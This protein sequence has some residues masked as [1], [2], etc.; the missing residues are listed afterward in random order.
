MWFPTGHSSIICHGN[1]VRFSTMKIGEQLNGA[2]TSWW[3][4]TCTARLWAVN[5]Y[6]PHHHTLDYKLGRAWMEKSGT[7]QPVYVL[8]TCNTWQSAISNVHEVS[9]FSRQISAYF[10][11]ASCSVLNLHSVCTPV[12]G[13][14]SCA[15]LS[16][17]NAL[18]WK[19]VRCSDSWQ[20]WEQ[21]CIQHT[22]L[23]AYYTNL[24][25]NGAY[26]TLYSSTGTLHSYV[27]SIEVFIR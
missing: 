6:I 10:A 11:W 13:V 4:T 25:T 21:Q 8:L 16:C 20:K 9:F 12:Q 26:P 1:N 7:T 15:L 5:T 3:A 19:N 23:D 17:E 18:Y 22:Q 27:C 2:F 24:T 14:W